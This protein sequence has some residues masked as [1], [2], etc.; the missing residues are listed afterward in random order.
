M[1]HLRS[2]A[3]GCRHAQLHGWFA[4][5][6]RGCQ[7]Q[8]QPERLPITEMDHGRQGVVLPAALLR[9]HQRPAQRGVAFGHKQVHRWG[10]DY[11]FH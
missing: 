9:S 3:A 5:E 11:A 1:R 6:G 7:F 8:F 10:A 4:L 2:I